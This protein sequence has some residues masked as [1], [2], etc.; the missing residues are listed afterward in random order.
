MIFMIELFFEKSALILT[1]IFVTFISS[2]LFTMNARGFIARGKYR[3]KEEAVIIYLS[4]T[5]LLGIITP[6]I[7]EGSTM[8]IRIVPALSIVGILIIGAN[9]IIHYSIPRWNQ[10]SIKSLLIYL[11]G[12]FLVILGILH[13]P[14]KYLFFLFLSFPNI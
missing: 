11:L 12:V 9:F 4:A 6:L 7:H 8:I 5:F 1:G 2:F 14:E 13:I 3:K 10:T